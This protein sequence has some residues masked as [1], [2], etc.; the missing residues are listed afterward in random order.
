MEEFERRFASEEACRACIEALRWP[1]GFRCP[2]C[3]G[4]TAAMVRAGL[5]QCRSCRRQTSVTAGTIFQDTPKPLVIWV[6]AMLYVTGP[7]NG[8]SS[9]RL[10]PGLGLGRYGTGLALVPKL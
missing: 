6:P 10:P 3:Q 4:G 9:P 5:Y 2:A 7:K 8:A 1:E